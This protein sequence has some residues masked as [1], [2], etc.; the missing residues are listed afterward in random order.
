MPSQRRCD[1]RGAPGDQKD[2]ADEHLH[3]YRPTAWPS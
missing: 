3:G 1:K 2:V